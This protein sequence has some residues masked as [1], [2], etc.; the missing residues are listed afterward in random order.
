MIKHTISL[1]SM[2]EFP[3]LTLLTNKMK[4]YQLLYNKYGYKLGDQIST[5]QTERTSK[6]KFILQL[7]IITG[8]YAEAMKLQL[9]MTLVPS[10]Q[11]TNHI[12]PL[13]AEP[14]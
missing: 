11:Y 4:M 6:F 5:I 10:F 9:G 1:R 7:E 2:A 8:I 3:M 14:V 13:C 12:F